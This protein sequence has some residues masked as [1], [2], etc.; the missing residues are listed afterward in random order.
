MIYQSF[1]I[2]LFLVE[3]FLNNQIVLRML[4]IKSFP[5]NVLNP[6]TDYQSWYDSVSCLLLLFLLHCSRMK[7]DLQR[8]VCHGLSRWNLFETS[9]NVIHLFISKCKL[10]GTMNLL[11]KYDFDSILLQNTSW[12]QSRDNAN[13][14]YFGISEQIKLLLYKCIK[15][16]QTSCRSTIKRIEHRTVTLCLPVCAHHK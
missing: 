14:F 9:R 4:E 12:Q 16:I 15:W 6:I 11:S 1:T 7:G 13:V 3:P 8:T 2:N 10:C 5:I